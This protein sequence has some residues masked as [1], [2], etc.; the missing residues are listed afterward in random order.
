MNEW[1]Q[2]MLERIKTLWSKWS[3]IQKAILIGI[4]LAVIAGTVLLFRFSSAPSM[5]RLLGTPV[6]NEEVMGRITLRLD[7]EGVDYRISEENIIL[8]KD[9][10]TA[11]RIRSILIR[12]DLVPNGIDPW[13]IFDEERWTLTDFERDVNLRRAITRSLEQH[14]TALSDVDKVNINLV[15][16]KD[17]LFAEDQNPATASIII[18]P[19]PGSDIGVNR[20]KIE[21]IVKLVQY[22]VEGLK[23]D[24]I[25]IT[26]HNG[27]LLNDFAGMED[28]DSLEL[29]KRQMKATR[30]LEN[31]Y[32][33][34]ILSEMQRIYGNDRVAILRVDIIQDHGKKKVEREEFFPIVM[35]E[36]N[37]ETPYSELEVKD[38][39]VIS[40]N[41]AE[42]HWEGTGINP[43][44][45]PGQ[46][47]QV[48][49][50]YKDM[51]NNVGKYDEANVIKNHAVSS[52]KTKEEKSSGKIERVSISVALDG[53]WKKKYDDGGELQIGPDGSIE[54][55]YVPIPEDNLEKARELIEAAIGYSGVRGDIV[56]V[57]NIQFD[58]SAEFALEDEAYK[59]QQMVR[60]IL[61]YSIFGLVGLI[62]AFI[63]FRLIMREM[64]RRRRL[65]EEELARQHQAMRE[66]ALRSAEEAEGMDVAMS[67]EER[68]RMELQENAINIAREHP[69]D[70]AQL[71]R[72]WLMEEG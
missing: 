8:V 27:K 30:D 7:Q 47:G 58:R 67:V 29:T 20:K 9:Q 54:R 18:T 43:E 64:E 26:D 23:E 65:R 16:P 35:K 68:A 22:A 56:T 17:A 42:K 4:V 70:V 63:A 62:I 5:V 14:I 12:E 46:E 11:R 36:D 52:E 55:E 53:T 33:R 59:R 24:A 50:A 3:L 66:A 45:P 39:L 61:L 40:E 15:I 72:T 44:G 19:K 1:L 48:P 25:T 37:P 10:K 21:G 2:K 13:D 51:Q 38:S 28:L 31:Q 60:Q 41:V 49:P 6:Q 71:I 32:K 34:V 57:Q 69:E